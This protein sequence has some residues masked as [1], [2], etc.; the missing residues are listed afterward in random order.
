MVT[1]CQHTR[2]KYRQRQVNKLYNENDH[3][4]T[5]ISFNTF[6]L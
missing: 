5:Y 2:V 1:I 4:N 6:L 3:N